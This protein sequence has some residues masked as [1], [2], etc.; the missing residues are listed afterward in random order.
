MLSPIGTLRIAGAVPLVVVAAA[1]PATSP[2][3]ST[4]VGLPKPIMSIHFCSARLPE[5]LVGDRDRADVR[6][7][8]QDLARAPVLDLVVVRVGD[9]ARGRVVEVLVYVYGHV[10]QRVRRDHALLQRAHE[11]HELERRAGLVEVGDRAQPPLGRRCR[12]G[13]PRRH[14]GRGG[15]REDAAG[16]RVEHD[17]RDGLRVPVLAR[18]RDLLLHER[19][20]ARV[21]RQLHRLARHRLAHVQHARPVRVAGRPVVDL[22]DRRQAVARAQHVVARELDAGDARRRRRRRPGRP[23]RPAGRCA[24]ARSAARSRATSTSG[25]S[26]GSFLIR[27]HIDGCEAARR[28]HEL[29]APPHALLDRRP[30]SRA[31]TARAPARTR[32]DRARAPAT[33]RP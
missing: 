21:E 14:A 16:A 5:L 13:S 8:R 11:R 30:A 15:H 7:V 24:A 32:G 17:R 25:P 9:R 6:G 23:G 20:D 1:C 33:R 3:R 26:V 12:R 29:R 2:G 19:L 22:R 28:E 18:V 27:V 10:E 31:R 4:P